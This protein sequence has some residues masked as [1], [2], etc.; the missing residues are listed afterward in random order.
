MTTDTSAGTAGSGPLGTDLD[1]KYMLEV[2]A[3]GA[4]DQSTTGNSILRVGQFNTR[5]KA[6]HQTEHIV[7]T[8]V[9]RDRLINILIDQ[10]AAIAR[11]K[12]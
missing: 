7:L 3:I 9:E 11:V 4:I 10:R 6:W 12:I 5:E 1:Q 8:P 2:S